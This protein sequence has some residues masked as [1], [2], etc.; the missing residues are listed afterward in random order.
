MLND[1]I[2]SSQEVVPSLTPP[3]SGREAQVMA[4]PPRDILSQAAALTEAGGGR[5]I[6]PAQQA[7]LAQVPAGTAQAPAVQNRAFGVKSI[8]PNEFKITHQD[9]DLGGKIISPTEV[10]VVLGWLQSLPAEPAG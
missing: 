7:Q 5:Y 6:T 9:K 1:P 8:A 10:P 4:E 3:A 2:E